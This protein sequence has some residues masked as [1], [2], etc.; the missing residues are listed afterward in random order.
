MQ[1][2][3]CIIVDDNHKSCRRL[4]ELLNKFPGI[5]VLASIGNAEEAVQKIVKEQPALV[6]LEVE[7][8]CKTG[9]DI[10]KDVRRK[11]VNS[12]F[13]FVTAHKQ[14][15]IKAL[16]NAAFDYLVKPVDID[17]LKEALER[18]RVTI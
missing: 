17:E 10:V 9:F 5:K 11:F 1:D 8:P 12:D 3:R 4:E 6:F 16:R 7:M 14:Y 15:A 13:I 18:A 2:I